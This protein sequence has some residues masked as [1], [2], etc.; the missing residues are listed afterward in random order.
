MNTENQTLFRL[1]NSRKTILEMLK[2]RGYNV[3]SELVIP[4]NDFCSL[5]DEDSDEGIDDIR[6]SKDRNR[7]PLKVSWPEEANINSIQR[8]AADMEAEDL[9]RVILVIDSSLTP[10]AKIA[11][12]NLKTQKFHIEIFTVTE[13]QV[14]ISRNALVPKHYLCPP[15]KKERILKS[16]AVEPKKIP[17]I[18]RTD[19]MARYLGALAGNMIQ[20][21]RESETMPGKKIV[22]FR[23]VVA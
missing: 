17:Q 13:T 23:I 3:P 21:I 2:D 12:R 9:H 4:W 16:Y 15:S 5:K 18:K 10:Q 1:W 22:T 19:P 7:N 6:V 20:I 11:I 14:N 8:V